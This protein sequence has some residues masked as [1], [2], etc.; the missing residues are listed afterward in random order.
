MSVL[1]EE[2]IRDLDARQNILEL[3][4]H[5]LQESVGLHLQEKFLAL[6][7]WGR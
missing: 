3:L 4:L 5:M 7:Y 6:T 2:I 1:A